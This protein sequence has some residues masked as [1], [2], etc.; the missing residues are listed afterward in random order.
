MI[1][2][3]SKSN[4]GMSVQQHSTTKV[5]SISR[6]EDSEPM[7]EKC[8][9]R[10]DRK[11]NN[12]VEQQ[13]GG[14][15]NEASLSANNGKENS[16]G[17]IEPAYCLNCSSQLNGRLLESMRLLVKRMLHEGKFEIRDSSPASAN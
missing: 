13:V 4:L 6:P 2:Q 5:L 12:V 1:T 11:T 8:R 10:D 14:N 7:C 9:A 3:I 16:G 17:N 15:A